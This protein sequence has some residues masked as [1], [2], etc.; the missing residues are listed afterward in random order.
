M[1]R[2]K[3]LPPELRAEVVTALYRDADGLGW[4]T[5]AL[6]ERTRAYA[7]WVEVPEI[8]GVLGRFM[9]PEQARSWIKDGPM[10]EYGRALRGAGRFASHGRQGGTGPHDVVLHALGEDAR[11]VSG[12][13]GSKP[14]HCLASVSGASR[15]VTWGESRNFRNL[16]WAALR[17]A[18]DDGLEAHVVVMEPLGSA[19]PHDEMARQRAFADRCGVRLHHMREIIGT[20]G[21]SL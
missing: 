15:Y 17:A 5:L 1:T 3:L 12:S 18:V 7:R 20:P 8:G 16:I 11:I 21:G 19:T 14:L 4:Q 13:V 9:T 10:K 2:E 6:A